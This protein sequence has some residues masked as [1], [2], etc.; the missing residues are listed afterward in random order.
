MAAFTWLVALALRSTAVLAVALGL[1]ALL[2]RASAVA[3]HRLLT[4][5]ALGLLLLPALPGV[6]PRWELGF[7]PRWMGTA[8]RP[9]AV[10]AARSSRGDDRAGG[11]VVAG[12][13]ARLSATRPAP[14]RSVASL[15]DLVRN[16]RR[17]GLVGGRPGQ[18]PGAGA[19]AA[20]R[21]ASCGRRHVR[22]PDRW[23]ETPWGGPTLSRRTRSGPPAHVRRR[24]RRR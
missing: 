6:L 18:P 12:R 13:P 11:R 15:G 17:R 23:L 2:R 20:A 7:M 5:A 9:A 14:E 19:S 22:S 16:R 3:R 4:L 24:S 8:S 21:E 1:G 10:P